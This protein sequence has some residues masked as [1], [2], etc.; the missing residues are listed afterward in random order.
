MNESKSAQSHTAAVFLTPVLAPQGVRVEVSDPPTDEAWLREVGRIARTPDLRPAT[1]AERAAL[2][3]EVQQPGPQQGKVPTF[4][5][6][7]EGCKGVAVNR[8]GPCEACK[9]LARSPEA[10]LSVAN[11]RLHSKW[12]SAAARPSGSKG[13]PVVPRTGVGP[14][15]AW[16]AGVRADDQRRHVGK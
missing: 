14:R 6:A 15:A 2:E 10:K 1:A 12:R 7:K 5:C 11:D 4:P 13:R 9:R 3:A 16:N 8:P